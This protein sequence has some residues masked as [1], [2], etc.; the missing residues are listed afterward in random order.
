MSKVSLSNIDNPPPKIYRR[1]VN[2]SI[3]FFIPMLTGLIQSLNMKH[4]TRNICMVGITAIPFLLKGIGMVL[5]NGEVYADISQIKE[6]ELQP[7]VEVK[8]VEE[9]TQKIDISKFPNTSAIPTEQS[10][11]K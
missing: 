9:Q 5:G 4:E 11:D 2:A 3:I 8:P 1:F 7:V 10:K 6:S